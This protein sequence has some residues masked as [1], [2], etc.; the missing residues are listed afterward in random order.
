MY[1]DIRKRKLLIID[2]DEATR[3]LIAEILTNSCIDIIEADCGHKALYLFNKYSSEIALVLLDIRLPNCSGW[4]L[5]GQFR[6]ENYFIPIIAISAMDP[7]EL[8]EK[9]RYYGFD[10]YLSKPFDIEDLKRI[11]EFYLRQSIAI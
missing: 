7:K 6:D 9:T 11:V 3:I 8:R 10:S 1:Q 5:I 2:D 4:E